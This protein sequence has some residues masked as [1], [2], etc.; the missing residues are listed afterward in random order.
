MCMK[1][2]PAVKQGESVTDN[3]LA[4]ARKFLR[5]RLAAKSADLASAP[6]FDSPYPHKTKA[7]CLATIGFGS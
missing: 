2:K 1:A 4:A 6:S 5:P 7:Y 3:F